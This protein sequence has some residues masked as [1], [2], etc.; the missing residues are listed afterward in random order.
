M[1]FKGEADYGKDHTVRQTFYGFRVHVRLCW[2]GVI[3]PVS[4]APAHVHEGEVVFELTEGTT[5]LLQ[6]VCYVKLLRSIH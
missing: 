4:L 2:P 5:A 3:T 6:Q 1:R